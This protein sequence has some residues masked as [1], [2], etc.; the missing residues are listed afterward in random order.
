VICSDGE[1]A[2][3]VAT[4]D[5]AHEREIRV[6]AL[7]GSAGGKVGASLAAEDVQI[8]IPSDRLARVQET[9]RL[10]LNCLCDGAYATASIVYY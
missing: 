10:V 8:C 2:A 3:L 7:T 6:V 9:H 4:I 1:S 5:A